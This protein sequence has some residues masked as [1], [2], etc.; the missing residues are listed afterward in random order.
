MTGWIKNEYLHFGKEAEELAKEVG[1]LTAYSNTETLRVRKEP[2]LEAGIVGLLADGQAVEAI[3]E[4][5]D[6]VKVSYEGPASH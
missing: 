2:N 5:G 6:W 1:V 4:E 3:A